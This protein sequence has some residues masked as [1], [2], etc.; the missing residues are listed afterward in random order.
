MS[1]ANWE[2]PNPPYGGGLGS[3]SNDNVFSDATTSCASSAT[4][5]C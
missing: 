3:R 5:S 2:Y 4:A 1:S